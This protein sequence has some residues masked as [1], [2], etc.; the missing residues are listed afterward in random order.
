[1]SDHLINDS[2]MQINF[3]AYDQSLDRLSF[4]QRPN[5]KNSGTQQWRDL[6]FMHWD[7]P[8]ELAQ[9]LLPAGL[10]LDLYDGKAWIAVVPFAMYGVK[11][12]FLPS[13]AAFNF[14][15]CNVRLYVHAKGKPGV[16]FLSLEAASWLAVQAARIGW[17]LPYFYAQMSSKMNSQHNHM[18]IQYQSRR[19]D[20]IGLMVNYRRLDFLG[21]SPVGSLAF[22]F[23]ERYLLF[24]ERGERLY[25][26]Q[27]YHTPYPVYQA[28]VLEIQENLIA[29]HGGDVTRMPTYIHASIGVDVEVFSLKPIS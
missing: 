11:P 20:Q 23:L 13:W 1:M 25:C 3:D 26:G 18:N 14:L 21:T 5:G 8:I 29:S 28:E 4:R 17:K 27:V 2:S 15:E 22:F 16:Y 10:S 7:I 6:L 19:R 9:S 12:S 24:V